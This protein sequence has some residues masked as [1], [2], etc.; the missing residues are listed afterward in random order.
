MKRVFKQWLC[1]ILITAILLGT[2]A[3]PGGSRASAEDSIAAVGETAQNVEK[4]LAYAN[5]LK[6]ANAVNRTTG[7]FTWDTESKTRSW[8]YYN[9]LMMDAF[10]MIGPSN[11]SY[12]DGFYNANIS[13]NGTI[14]NF[15][16]G[17]LDSVEPI[18]AAFDMFMNSGYTS[19][20]SDKYKLCIQQVYSMLAHQI[21]YS[22]CGGNY[23]H[24]QK[25]G[26]IASTSWAAY[27]IALDGIYMAQP[28]L[29]EC[30]RAIEAGKL[31]LRSKSGQNVTADSIYNS[32][33]SRLI[34]IYDN[35]YNNGTGLY[36]HAANPSGQ[37]N[38]ITW[39]R[40]MGWYAMALVDC[41]ELMPEGAKK[42]NLIAELRRLYEGLLAH[43]CPGGVP[44][45]PQSGGL[46]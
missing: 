33:Y 42:D 25:D 19:G 32:V 34:W 16:S 9:G 23:A 20:N 28:F 21:S 40:A 5:Q 29:M 12:V 30:A 36:D 46:Y 38:G 17:E 22:A 18:R 31:T 41:I 6:S 10:A 26:S 2:T 43:R 35:L 14:T 7:K 27:P 15:T 11:Y 3:L 45:R 1:A 8:T 24:K 37:T 44:G 4:V 13:S 39:S